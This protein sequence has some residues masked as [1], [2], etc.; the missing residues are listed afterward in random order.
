MNAF[1]ITDMKKGKMVIREEEADIHEGANDTSSLEKMQK[2]AHKTGAVGN[3]KAT[4]F[5]EDHEAKTEHPK[6]QKHRKNG[7][8]KNLHG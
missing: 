8:P 3:V 1:K 7:Y 5:D 6:S 2:N 4:N